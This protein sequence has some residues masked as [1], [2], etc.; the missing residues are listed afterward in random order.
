MSSMTA[1]VFISL[2][3]L[4]VCGLL[5]LRH[6]YRTA[7]LMPPTSDLPASPRH[8]PPTLNREEDYLGLCV[9]TRGAAERPATKRQ[10]ARLRQEELRQKPWEGRN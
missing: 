7:P 2:G 8:R 3:G 4:T 5:V 9:R 1:S 6:A 10:M